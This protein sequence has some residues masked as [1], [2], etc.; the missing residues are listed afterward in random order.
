MTGRSSQRKGAAVLTGYG[1]EIKCGSS[2]FFGEV[3]NL[4]S[5]WGTY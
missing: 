4:A 5:F 2:L 1:Y 3:P